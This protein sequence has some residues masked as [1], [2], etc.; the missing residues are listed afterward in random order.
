M[1]HPRRAAHQHHGPGRRAGGGELSGFAALAGGDELDHLYL[2]PD[3]LRRGIRS[4][5]PAEAREA[6]GGPL[7][8]YVFQ[9]NAPARAF[10]ERQGFVAGAF[11]DGS[12]DEEGEPDVLYCWRPA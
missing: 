8:L 11:D 2:R 1:D 12:R 5:L 7:Q 9:R 4:R 10:C 3:V 6:A